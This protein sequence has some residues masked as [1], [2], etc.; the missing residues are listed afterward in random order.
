MGGNSPSRAAAMGTWP[1]SSVQP[2]SAPIDD[3]I[4]AMEIAVAP[5]GSP[6][7]LGRI[8]ERRDRFHQLLAR[9]D[10][11]DRDRPEHIEQHCDRDAEDG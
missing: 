3:R 11:H 9:H 6:E 7:Y 1:M 10:P 8:G 4:T 2:L 5:H